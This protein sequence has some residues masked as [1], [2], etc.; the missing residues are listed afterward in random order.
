MSAQAIIEAIKAEFEQAKINSAARQARIMAAAAS[1]NKGVDPTVD[2][3]GRLH[4][5]V[6]GYEWEDEIYGA[7]EFLPI[8][9]LSLDDCEYM[10]ILYMPKD[11]FAERYN[12]KAKIKTTTSIVSQLKAELSNLPVAINVSAG[13]SW[14]DGI[15][16]MY[17]DAKSKRFISAIE[18]AA[19]SIA[20]V[21]SKSN[22][23]LSAGRQQVIATMKGTFMKENR[24]QPHLSQLVGIFER[25]DG[26]TLF[27]N[28][29]DSFLNLVESNIDEL[30]GKKVSFS[31]E[32]IVNEKYPSK[33]SCKRPTKVSLA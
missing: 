33:A 21:E 10:D 8:P 19:A 16:Y 31:A 2:K 12:H 20:P 1:Q 30:K 15:C 3:Y 26:A 28:I 27:C 18:A 13:A 17:V 9:E 32:L 29:G 23:V 5:P 6:D 22:A 11:G 25:D 7:G 24:Y 4:A 14:G